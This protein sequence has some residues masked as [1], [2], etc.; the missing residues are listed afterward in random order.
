MAMLPSNPN[1]TRLVTVFGGSGFVGR[2]V[3]RALAQA[4]WRVRVA[5]RRPDLAFHLQPLG[6]V[7]Q[8]QLVQA[9]VRYPAS[10]ASAVKGAD[11]IVNLVGVLTPRGR[12]GFEAVHAFGARTIALA[13]KLAGIET[14]I[15][16]SAI[17]ADE[18]SEASYARSKGLGERGVREALPSAS[19]VRPSIIFG[20]EDDFF[21][22][23]A[24]IARL[25]PVLPLFG[26]GNTKFQPVYVGDVANA[27][28]RLCEGDISGH[29]FEL[30]G[31]DVKSF[32]E[33]M[34]Y[35]CAETGR[36]RLFAPIPWGLAKVP[37]FGLE[38]ANKLSFGIWPDWLT[39]TRDQ[40]ELLKSN[41]VVS[42]NAAA[43][44]RTLQGL[45]IQPESFDTI[46]PTYLY[47]FRKAGQ[48]EARTPA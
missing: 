36:S 44:G 20:P 27:I 6:R 18:N 40:I 34:R 8:I 48:F 11:A 30:G 3:V 15:H 47:R 41:N 43:E 19:I 9:N 35:I 22:R 7:G 23:F 17:G 46:V 13:A 39:V 26:G 45:G 37:A 24:A 38:L 16:V 4:G 28:T 32:E 31:P 12:Q 5:C 1:H 29:T 10:V 33:L 21:N 25:S 2:H 42:T 14:F